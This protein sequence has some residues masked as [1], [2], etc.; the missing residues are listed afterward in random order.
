MKKCQ[1]FLHNTLHLRNAG[2]PL[3]SENGNRGKARERQR[4]GAVVLPP[5]NSRSNI[6]Q[7]RASFLPSGFP[8]WS[9]GGPWPPGNTAAAEGEAD[10]LQIP[11]FSGRQHLRQS[12]HAG[13]RGGE[14]ED[15][16]GGQGGDAGRRGATLHLGHPVTRWHPGQVGEAQ[17]GGHSLPHHQADPVSG[18]EIFP[19]SL[20]PGRGAAV[21]PGKAAGLPP[22]P[23]PT[24]DGEGWRDAGMKP[25]PDGCRSNGMKNA[26]SFPPLSREEF[27]LAR[28]HLAVL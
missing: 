23:C 3:I 13:R 25:E 2:R 15:E 10:K 19:V 21:G 1:G 20:V 8:W 6:L 22:V 9:Q 18:A 7:P 27:S 4:C 24:E 26:C 12:L 11:A 16:D 28:S 14:D 5:P 17:R